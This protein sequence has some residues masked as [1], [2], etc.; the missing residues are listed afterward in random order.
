[1]GKSVGFCGLF[2]FVVVM[3]DAAGVDCGVMHLV[4]LRGGVVLVEG[5]L[6]GSCCQVVAFKAAEEMCG[7]EVITDVVA[8]ERSEVIECA[9]EAQVT[10][11][12]W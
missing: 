5:T 2:G 1:M 10:I 9:C 12:N 3:Q 7:G 6:Y 11:N 4:M 8:D